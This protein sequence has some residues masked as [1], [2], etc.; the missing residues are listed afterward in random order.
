MNV[1][2]M[3]ASPRGGFVLD[4]FNVADE[5]VQAIVDLV[6]FHTEHKSDLSPYF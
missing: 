2:E 3:K 4:F 6:I 5:I 1:E